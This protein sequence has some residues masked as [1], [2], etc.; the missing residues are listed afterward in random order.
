M[1]K[2]IIASSK[3]WHHS[4]FQKTAKKFK[5]HRWSYVSSPQEL[6]SR[7]SKISPNYIFFLH[8]SWYVPKEILSKSEC[9][10]F[11]MTDVPYGRGGSPLQN[12]ILRR[13][14]KTVVAAL[15]MI[16]KLD[17]GPVYIKKPLSLGGRAEEIYLRAGDLC[18]KIIAWI[19]KKRPTPKLQIG[20]VVKFHRR[21]PDQSVLPLRGSLKSL[22]D[23]IRMLDAP[24]YPLAFLEYGK[25]CLK[26]SRAS[27]SGNELHAHV[28]IRR[29][30]LPDEK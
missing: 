17:A 5:R 1:V 12:L 18:W 21:K 11:H 25:F 26:F 4:A 16:D 10:C 30:S 28:A 7:L 3:K 29:R 6:V 19:I 2:I 15:Q 23:F 22:Y 14:K 8:W 20:K 13:K 9:I 24:T 27:F